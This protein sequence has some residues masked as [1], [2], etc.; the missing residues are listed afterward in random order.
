MTVKHRKAL[1]HTEYGINRGG[2]VTNIAVAL[3][4]R[5]SI[6]LV[7]C[8]TK[9]AEPKQWSGLMTASGGR[10]YSDP[11]NVPGGG[12]SGYTATRYVTADA[13][14]S[15]DGLTPETPWTFAQAVANADGDHKVRVAPGVYSVTPINSA[16]SPSLEIMGSGDAANEA[17]RLVFFA[18]YPAAYNRS[19]PELWSEIR[20]N[21]SAVLS[22]VI[23]CKGGIDSIVLDGF[24]IDQSHTMP[25]PSTG[26]VYFGPGQSGTESTDIHVRRCLFHNVE[27][28]SGDNYASIIA[29]K[30]T[31]FTITD[32]WF[33]GGAG[34][35]EGDCC[36]MYGVHDFIFEHNHMTG[37]RMG[38]Y[39]KGS[40]DSATRW[41]Y[42]VMRYN[43][44]E[45][46]DN[47]VWFVSEVHTAQYVDI[48]QNLA[49]ACCSALRGDPAG[50][51]PS[52][53]R[54][55]NNTVVNSIEDP[56]S[57]FG[58]G[59]ACLYREGAAAS[60]DNAFYNNIVANLATAGTI[61]LLMV[62][63]ADPDGSMGL[64][65]YN[66][67]WNNG[68]SL[69]FAGDINDTIPGSAMNL[70]A[71]RTFIDGEANSIDDNPD[72]VNAG[73]GDYHLQVGSPALT[74]GNTGGPCGCYITGSEEIG[75]RASPTY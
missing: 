60:T 14:G 45:D 29:K 25:R 39:A 22:A 62:E 6:K 63:A 23:G 11:A 73:T 75:L 35:G 52:R 13:T 21:N 4:R 5:R 44:A 12:E 30:C 54:C 40:T 50:I 2:D 48:Y 19:S 27:Q 68:S 74:A 34:D 55:F 70:A 47:K 15:D 3:A 17:G 58:Y 16:E 42:G 32:C 66:V 64:I 37:T 49:V 31:S 41:N 1:R 24:F 57:G 61:A 43:Y 67:Y 20:S 33:Q 8:A 9:D 51:G 53:L 26:T 7:P 69:Y 46:V 72:F 18:Q 65:D 56:A 71:W 36:T 28:P 38:F 10:L 59:H